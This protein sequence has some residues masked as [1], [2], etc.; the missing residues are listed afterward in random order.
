MRADAALGKGGRAF[1]GV[2]FPAPWPRW[3]GRLKPSATTTESLT[4]LL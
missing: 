2:P 1:I 4:V 3:E